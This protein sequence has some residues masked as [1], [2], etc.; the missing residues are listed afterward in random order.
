MRGARA[1]RLPHLY[2]FILVSGTWRAL[3]L[4]AQTAADGAPILRRSRSL[5]TRPTLAIGRLGAVAGHESLRSN[6]RE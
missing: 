4:R 3:P 1:N 6:T 2:V 5:I